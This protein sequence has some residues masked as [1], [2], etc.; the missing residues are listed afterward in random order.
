LL[1]GSLAWGQGVKLP[2]EVRATR[3][4]W[5]VIAPEAIDGGPPQWEIDPGLQ[6]VRLDLL[7]PPEML[8]QL[9]GKVVTAARDG[10]YTVTAW[11]AKGDKAS[12]LSRCTVLVGDFPPGPTPPKPVPPDPPPDPPDVPADPELLKNVQAAYA[13]DPAVARKAEK[14]A[15]LAGLYKSAPDNEVRD[16]ALRTMQDLLAKLA[17][18]RRQEIPDAELVNT[19][20]AVALWLGQRL[21]PDPAAATLDA[22]T[23]ERVAGLFRTVASTLAE[24]KP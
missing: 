17:A 12:L 2:A 8:A 14:L 7:L 5:I 1:S 6:E 24:V 10:R 15:F 11:N 18:V 19:R 22:A 4:S 23:R 21:P 20:N 3:G 16:P 13:R 9:K